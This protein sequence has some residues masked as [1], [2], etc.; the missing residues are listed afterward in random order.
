[1]KRF[2]FIVL[3]ALII[4]QAALLG[5]G[6]GMQRRAHV[7]FAEMS[8]RIESG[9]TTTDPSPSGGMAEWRELSARSE[10]VKGYGRTALG[11]TLAVCLLWG[12]AFGDKRAWLTPI[13]AAALAGLAVFISFAGSGEGWMNYYVELVPWG[14]YS[15]A[16]AALT[17]LAA[18]FRRKKA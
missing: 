1:M 16:A 18:Y 14:A 8:A 17:A 15:L 9:T 6:A 5:V 2:L 7:M 12:A 3:A 13:V 4:L 10:R 11:V